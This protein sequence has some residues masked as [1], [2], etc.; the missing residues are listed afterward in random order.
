MVLLHSVR[1]THRTRRQGGRATQFIAALSLKGSFQRCELEDFF[2]QKGL[3][4]HLKNRL[5]RVLHYYVTPNLSGDELRAVLQ[6]ITAPQYFP[7]QLWAWIGTWEEPCAKLTQCVDE[8]NLSMLG[9]LLHRSPQHIWC[10]VDQSQYF[11]IAHCA[12]DSDL[13]EITIYLCR[14][15]SARA[16]TGLNQSN[17]YDETPAHMAARQ[18][19]LTHLRQLINCDWVD[20]LL[21]DPL[22]RTCMHTL[23]SGVL[24]PSSRTGKSMLE[25]ISV[26]SDA[27]ARCHRLAEVRDH[28]GWTVADYALSLRSVNMLTVAIQPVVAADSIF[29]SETGIADFIVVL[30]KHAILKSDP[31]LLSCLYPH[32]LKFVLGNN[33]PTRPVS[34]KKSTDIK[35]PSNYSL[36]DIIDFAVDTMS[37]RALHFLCSNASTVLALRQLGVLGWTPVPRAVISVG[38]PFSTDYTI[39]KSLLGYFSGESTWINHRSDTAQRYQSF[40]NAFSIASYLGNIDSLRAL[41]ISSG[42]VRVIPRNRINNSDVMCY[43]FNRHVYKSNPIV[44]AILGRNSMASTSQQAIFGGFNEMKVKYLEMIR[45]L[46]VQTPFSDIKNAP[47]EFE[48]G[49]GKRFATSPLAQACQALD[50]EVVQLLCDNGC[51]PLREIPDFFTG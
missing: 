41:L 47:Q 24:R 28:S 27:F 37:H 13:L 48:N 15:T 20:L 34:K 32:F 22:G 17:F 14:S 49:D 18:L 6:E 29:N 33:E 21:I 5:W 10:F 3:H 25:I 51:D 23:L 46:L 44:A 26:V 36:I 39:L 12:V 4:R 8:K 30:L 9:D 38:G 7:S 50:V 42:A 43:Y 16:R 40:D 19:K 31:A 11:N 1:N 35:G 2:K 45:Y